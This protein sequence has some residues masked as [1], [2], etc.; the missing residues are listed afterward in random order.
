MKLTLFLLT[1]IWSFDAF[2]KVYYSK[3]IKDTD[4]GKAFSTQSHQVGDHCLVGHISYHKDLSGS[5]DYFQRVNSSNIRRRTFGEVHGG[6]NLFIVAGSVSTSMTHR[7]ATDNKTM[8]SQLHLKLDEGYSTLEQRSVKNGKD[9]SQCGTHFIYQ[10]NYGRDIF[11]NTRLHF[12][13]E[14]DFKRFVIKIKIRLLFFKKTFTKIREIEKYA[15]NAVFSVDVNSNGP[16]PA[17]LQAK[18][19]AKP[20]HCSGKN[21]SP[22]L[23]TLASLVDYSFD[24]NGLVK[25]LAQLEKV[26]RS[27]VVVGF[28]DSGHYGAQDWQAIQQN[29]LY[30]QT[31]H[32]VEAH[33]GDAVRTLQRAEAFLAV[34]SESEKPQLEAQKAAAEQALLDAT[35]LRETCFASPWLSQCQL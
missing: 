15:E 13:T 19:N 22:C 21:I 32:A 3:Q 10:V 31:W 6:V 18:L 26:P 33:F 23:E 34:A 11:I 5:L 7:N 14:E 2:S 35:Q 4:L 29:Y 27:F 16:L 9:L 20:T 8:T 17:E 30:E 28:Q 12:R 24:A 1:M 25:D